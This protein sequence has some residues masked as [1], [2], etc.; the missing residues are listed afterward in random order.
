MHE[1]TDPCTGARHPRALS[2]RH[3]RDTTRHCPASKCARKVH[4]PFRPTATA[5]D[6]GPP[7]PTK[8]ASQGIAPCP[9]FHTHARR[10]QSMSSEP[11]FDLKLRRRTPPQTQHTSRQ[12]RPIR[13][14]NMNSG[15]RTMRHPSYQTYIDSSPSSVSSPS[16]F[17]ISVVVFFVFSAFF[18]RMFSFRSSSISDS[19]SFSFFLAPASRML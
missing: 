2:R 12:V 18:R 4:R 17:S 8:Y 16:S 5:Y 13:T 10:A 3:M 14:A 6:F 7:R 15:P 11:H 19:F 9:L 1:S